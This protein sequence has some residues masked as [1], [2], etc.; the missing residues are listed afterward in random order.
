MSM[1]WWSLIVLMG[2]P[3]VTSC[4]VAAAVCIDYCLHFN[5]LL[6]NLFDEPLVSLWWMGPSTR[7]L[8]SC[9]WVSFPFLE[10]IPVCSSLPDVVK[11]W[12]AFKIKTSIWLFKIVT[13]T[14]SIS[15]LICL[16]LLQKHY[17]RLVMKFVNIDSTV[18]A[19]GCIFGIRWLMGSIFCVCVYILY[20]CCC[21]KFWKNRR[22]MLLQSLTA[23]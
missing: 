12:R 11:H 3:N 16:S 15:I 8:Y 6:Y 14:L 23:I 2:R 10:K 18:H 9:P 19:F 22:N 21:L 5:I 17:D 7:T 13:H 4:F 1:L 20:Q